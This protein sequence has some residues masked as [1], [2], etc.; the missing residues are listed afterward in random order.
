M[1]ALGVVGLLLLWLG[2]IGLVSLFF[3]ERDG[4]TLLVQGAGVALVLAAFFSAVLLHFLSLGAVILGM[5]ILSVLLG[6]RA[7]KSGFHLEWNLR[8]WEALVLG[9]LSLMSFLYACFFLSMRQVAEDSFFL[10]CSNTGLIL[11]GTYPP[12]NFFG[13][14]LHGHYGQDLIVAFLSRLLFIEFLDAEWMF[15]GLANG[16]GLLLAYTWLL[17]ET[18]SRASSLLASVLLYFGANYCSHIGQFDFLNNNQGT[19]VLTW[20]VCSYA[21]FRAL[22]GKGWWLA[23]ILLGTDALVYEIHYVMMLGAFITLTA[24]KPL[25]ANQSRQQRLQTA[26][27]TLVLS[28][29]VAVAVGGPI[30]AQVL[31]RLT[32]KP[33]VTESNPFTQEVKVSFPKE[34]LFQLR[35]DNLRPSRPFET[36]LRSWKADFAPDNRY[37]PALSSAI[38]N[39]F[40]YPVWLGPVTLLWTLRNRS[41]A[42]FWLLGLG[43]LGWA[44]P[45]VVDFGYYEQETFRWL[46]FTAWCWSAAFGLMLGKLFE[47]PSGWKKW[48]GSSLGVV[49]L[50]VCTAGLP[51]EIKDGKYSW[52]HVGEPGPDGAPGRVK[53]VGFFPDPSMSLAHHYGFSL[54]KWNAAHWL[55]ENTQKEDLYLLDPG[56]AVLLD[57]QR[58]RTIGGEVLN[59]FGCMVGLSG[60]LPDSVVPD[61]VAIF[62][63]SLQSWVFW[64]TLDARLLDKMRARWLVVDGANLAPG[65]IDTLDASPQL[66]LKHREG[67][68]SIY[69][70]HPRQLG[71]RKATPKT[72]VRAIG[73]KKTVAVRQN[74]AWPVDVAEVP[75]SGL[76]ME[77]RVKPDETSPNPTPVVFE[78]VTGTTES[79]VFSAP[80]VA[81]SYRVDYR[82]EGRTEWSRFGVLTVREDA[83]KSSSDGGERREI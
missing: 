72:S 75:E 38:L 7:W 59:L 34:K 57:G 68:L 47:F 26:F 78:E 6:L 36:K 28:G 63:R 37:V 10:H 21:C 49:V 70:I 43:A 1:T 62:D 41:S 16:L 54:E 18:G 48:A 60:R 46:Y 17:R 32:P 58:P 3:R 35:Y 33:A 5:S 56:V 71:P 74:F 51:L 20:L 13:E 39:C 9:G 50:L 40:W 23:A 66:Q 31:S 14:Q 77:L 19:A 79:L 69:E 15:R 64:V 4:L 55:R 82:L 73:D 8:W 30:S 83:P 12:V 24:F 80:A 29:I 81:G 67:G 53:G 45:S 76:W 52:T 65:G 11:S 25:G 22:E 2:G 27:L 44:I 61:E 42:S